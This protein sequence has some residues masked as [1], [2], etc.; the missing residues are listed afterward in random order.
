MRAIGGNPMAPRPRDVLYT[1]G[2]EAGAT[3]M[4]R[5]VL[6]PARLAGAAI[7][8][9]L[10]PAWMAVP[11]RGET[12]TAAGGA[13]E[14]LL[15]EAAKAWRTR[16]AE[17]WA[18]LWAEGSREAER[19]FVR[20]AFSADQTTLEWLRRD[21]TGPES[22]RFSVDAQVFTAQE[23]QGRLTY[24]RLTAE[25][26][27]GGWQFVGRSDSSV[28]DGFV[29]VSL[30]GRAW[31]AHDL[32]LRLEDFEL[33]MEDGTLFSNPEPLD[34]TVFVFVGRG[35]VRFDPTPKAEREQLRRFSGTAALEVPV[36]WS[37]VRLHPTDFGRL[38]DS[39][40][41][42]VDP[43]AASRLDE[44]R[45]I[46]AER[47]GR[48]F[49]L[50]APLPGSPWW[51]LPSLGDAIVD[52]PW[53][54][55][56]VLTFALSAG[57]VEDLNL[58]D[59]DR[60]TQIC[61]YPSAAH[62]N[63]P[64]VQPLAQEVLDQDLSVRFEPDRLELVAVHRL[65]L[66]SSGSNTLR[67]KLHDDFRVSSV[68]SGD[69]TELLFF[70]VRGQGSIVISLGG[71]AERDRPFTVVT[72][73]AGRHDPAPVEH[74]LLQV[75]RVRGDFSS[76]PLI[77]PPPI[78]Y[79]NR[80][81]WYPHPAEETFSP[82]SAEFDTP[83]G[84]LAVTGGELRSLRTAARR[85]HAE[86]R[87]AQPGKFVTAIV[88]RLSE[89]GLRQTG[90]SA[91]RAFST[92][93]SR[94]LGVA[95][96]RASEQ[97]LAFYTQLFGPCP[98]PSLAL[99]AVD[100]RAPGG[101]SPPGLVYV[102]ERPAALRA[103]AMAEDPANFSDVTDFFIAHEL[104]HQWFGQG[105]AP[106]GYRERWLSE[107]WAQYAAALWVRQRQGESEFRD[108]MDRMARWAMRHDQAGPIHLGQRLGVLEGDARLYRAVVYDKGAWVLH[109]LREIVGDEAFFAGTRAYLE[110]H[111]FGK[112]ATSDLRE[113]LEQASGRD[114]RPYFERWVYETGLPRIVWSARTRRAEAGYETTVALRA[115]DAPGPLPVEVTI[116]V[117]GGKHTR[118]VSLDPTGSWTLTSAERPRGVEVNEDRGL[119]ARVERGDP[120]A[121]NQ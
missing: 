73:Y 12:P 111:R 114:L 74:E 91:L 8:V 102:Q 31:H 27:Q 72:R 48:S 30:G 95:E 6:H 9:L 121:P 46:F 42:E 15:E 35:R 65:R 1:A 22:T 112:V 75:A 71:I 44:A 110:R 59:R 26:R 77:E 25:R 57:E 100:A 19:G 68:R 99:I 49:V 93:R 79:S 69:G 13:P 94:S 4:R 98:Y 113:A 28:V 60:Q 78:V 88:G 108:M 7:V 20:D 32:T 106:V 64:L 5:T 29:H 41:L 66:R 70:R 52:F 34:P 47:S 61:A 24:W 89:V 119:L 51:L 56:R 67:L 38:I 117:S 84:W 107:A 39:S 116:S 14:A 83:E 105:T 96:L 16:D 53:R 50:D 23:P 33:R 62:A 36:Q 82:V 85:T 109:M 40:R 120:G 86:Y 37:F 2:T 118:R 3:R 101:H 54:H 21:S 55:G 63:Q 115:E 103:Q 104:A 87:L 76:S 58:F 81:A 97:I 45:Q 43:N 10:L 92:A 80:T 17:R 18:A 90:E 11:A